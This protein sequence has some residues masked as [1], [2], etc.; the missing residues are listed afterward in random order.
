MHRVAIGM[1][2]ADIDSKPRH[3]QAQLGDRL[4]LGLGLSWPR[5]GATPLTLLDELSEECAGLW[6]GAV[7]H[8]THHAARQQHLVDVANESLEFLV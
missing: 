3:V 4:H 6:V 2:L 1:V 7:D 8:N 5:P